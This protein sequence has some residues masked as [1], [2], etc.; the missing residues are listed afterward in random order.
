ME[1]TETVEENT[2]EGHHGEKR[3]G[4]DRDSGGRNGQGIMVR[5]VRR[6][7]EVTET[8]EDA[9]DRASW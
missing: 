6:G 1:V 7:M 3:H 4:G 2:L 9:M 8:R 5:R